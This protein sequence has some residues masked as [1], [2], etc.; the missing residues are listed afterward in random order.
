MVADIM[1]TMGVA[2]FITYYLFLIA[3]G[4]GFVLLGLCW[5]HGRM[6]GRDATS[7]EHFLNQ[8]EVDED[9]EQGFGFIQTPDITLVENWKQFL[10]VYNMSEFIQRVLFP[11]TH[12]PK[13]DGITMDD[14]EMNKDLILQKGDSSQSKQD[15]AYT[16]SDYR[17]ISDSFVNKYRHE[18][19]S[20]QRGSILNS[21]SS[22]YKSQ[23]SFTD[24]KND[25]NPKQI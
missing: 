23:T 8:Y 13:G 6:I 7:L 15:I 4:M 14:H 19:S 21:S 2:G 10:G 22:G 24:R 12:K 17:T 5:W 9:C 3:L 11:S 1:Q 18:S 20:W 16:S 25:A